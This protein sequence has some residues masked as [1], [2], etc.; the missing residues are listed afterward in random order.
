MYLYKNKYFQKL[1]EIWIFQNNLLADVRIC[2]WMKGEGIRCT[3]EN[4]SD[5]LSLD[6]TV[7]ERELDL[8]S[9]YVGETSRSERGSVGAPVAVLS[10]KGSLC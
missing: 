3:R 8:V 2:Y 10:K 1:I 7:C 6:C 9:L 5:R 4:I